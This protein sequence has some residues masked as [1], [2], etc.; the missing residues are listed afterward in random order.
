MHLSIKQAVCESNHMWSY[1]QISIQS[2]S[3]TCLQTHIQIPGISSPQ[4][5]PCGS[6]GIS[7]CRA[8]LLHAPPPG[9]F[10]PILSR[11]AFYPYPPFPPDLGGH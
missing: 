5:Q 6:L 11:A 9:R 8:A 3:V 10:Y 4:P 2:I 7:L 1:M